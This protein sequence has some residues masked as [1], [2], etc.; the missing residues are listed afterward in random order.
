M[1]TRVVSIRLTEDEYERLDEIAINRRMTVADMVRELIRQGTPEKEL[2]DGM[3]QIKEAVEEL[4]EMALDKGLRKILYQVVW[5][6]VAIEEMCRR[7][8]GVRYQ[9][10]IEEIRERMKE[11]AGH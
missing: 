3:S 4:R 5:N 7:L 6:G 11:Q 2:I 10:V 8:P 1:R 9:V